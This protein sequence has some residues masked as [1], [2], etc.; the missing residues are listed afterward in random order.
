LSGTLIGYLDRLLLQT[1]IL[2]G[3]AIIFC[4][5]VSVVFVW[6]LRPVLWICLLIAVCIIVRVGDLGCRVL[7][8]FALWLTAVSLLALLIGQMT[9][10]DIFLGVG[11][12]GS[13]MSAFLCILAYLCE[14]VHV[15]VYVN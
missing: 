1:K 6:R 13:T 14:C 12:V 5:V 2:R 15:L 10:V 7:S 4:V 8:R 3:D 9:E 11:F